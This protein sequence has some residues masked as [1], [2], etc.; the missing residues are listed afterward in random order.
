MYLTTMKDNIFLKKMLVIL[1]KMLLT[2]KTQ[3]Q[4]PILLQR[5]WLR[6]IF[7]KKSFHM[8]HNPED[9]QIPYSCFEIHFLVN[10]TYLWVSRRRAI[11]QYISALLLCF[12]ACEINSK[13]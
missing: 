1:K 7:N 5:K 2:P 4:S 12:K 6:I 8:F 9:F 11:A 13:A 10:E 3:I